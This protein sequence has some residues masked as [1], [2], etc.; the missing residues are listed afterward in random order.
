MVKELRN[1]VRVISFIIGFTISY[2]LLTLI[3]G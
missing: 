2:G 1:T 3:F